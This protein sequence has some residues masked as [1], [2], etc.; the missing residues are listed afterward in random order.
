VKIDIRKLLRIKKHFIY[1]SDVRRIVMELSENG[2]IIASAR[3]IGNG[4][5]NWSGVAKRVGNF[6]ATNED[7]EVRTK[8]T[9]EFTRVIDELLF[10][11]GGRTL[12]N[13]GS[14]NSLLNCHVLE[15]GDSMRSESTVTGIGEFIN[16]ALCLNSDGGGVGTYCKLRPKGAEVK[17]RGGHSTGLLSF[18]NAISA[19][20]DTVESGGNRRSGLLPIL[21]VTH[22]EVL[23]F[24]DA[25]LDESL[26]NNF[27]VSVGVTTEFLDAVEQGKKWQFV[28]NGKEYG[29]I[30]AKDLFD[31]IVNNI[32]KSGEPGLVNLE[33]MRTNNTWYFSPV[34]SLNLCGELPLSKNQSCCLGSL[35]LPN[36]LDGS[37]RT[38]WDSIE[39]TVRIGVRMLDNILDLND[40]PFPVMQKATMISRRIG[41]GV[42]GLAEYLFKKGVR[43]GS[44]KGLAEVEAVIKHIRTK[45]YEASIDLAKEKGIFPGFNSHAYSSAKFIKTLPARVRMNI[46]QYGIRNATLMAFAPT[47]TIS[48]V[49]D[50]T[51]GVEPLF[52]KAYVRRDKV[53][54]RYYVHQTY[55]ELLESP[56]EVVPDWFVDAFDLTPEEH[57]ETTATIQRLNDGSISKTQNLPRGTTH[58]QL[59]S[60]LLEY[61]RDLVG[62]TCYVDGSRQDQIMTPLSK[63][64]TMSVLNSEAKKCKL[65]SNASGS[66]SDGSSTGSCDCGN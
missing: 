45:L 63:E 50:T 13:A 55:K 5:T 59:S 40:Y 46:K 39:E 43:Y 44:D 35:V 18:L 30:W 32:L 15:L 47:G 51:S 36:F 57:F 52:S 6:V 7:K 14:T 37:G 66:T 48:L 56:G 31:K 24:I 29:E 60:W 33:R 23:D 58:E 53:G 61:I 27:N 26:L 34:E 16:M 4:D 3:Y 12:R 2:N 1:R 22:P 8:W 19:V 17:T 38:K 21:P 10:L 49:A 54:E 11:P 25:K 20:L 42:M 28:W 41:V 9:D 65:M 62:V 64:E